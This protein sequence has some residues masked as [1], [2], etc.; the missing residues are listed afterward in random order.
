M[1]FQAFW[2]ILDVDL[3]E[4]QLRRDALEDLPFLVIEAKAELT[5][6]PAFDVVTGPDGK[7]WYRCVAAAE[8]ARTNR[9]HVAEAVNAARRRGSLVDFTPCSEC[10]LPAGTSG[11]CTFHRSEYR[12]QRL[13]QAA[14]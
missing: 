12:K 5:G 10:D 4:S 3:T 14:A 9:V 6:R 11:M 8:K 13:K 1:I 2:P 7:L